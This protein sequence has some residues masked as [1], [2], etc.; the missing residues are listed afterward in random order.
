MRF[1]VTGGNSLASVSLASAANCDRSTNE[2]PGAG[3]RPIRGWRP[4]ECEDEGGWGEDTGKMDTR[5]G[6]QS[7]TVTGVIQR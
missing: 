7:V 4:G 3:P 5:E 2:R 6:L 1:S